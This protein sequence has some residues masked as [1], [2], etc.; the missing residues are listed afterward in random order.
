M[1]DGVASSEPSVASPSAVGVT[2]PEPRLATRKGRFWRS[3]GRNWAA[4]IGL[5]LLGVLIV[6]AIAA[7]IVAPYDPH[8]QNLAA[9]LRPLFWEPR[10]DLAH[11]L[12]TD[13]LGRDLLSRVIYGGRVSL[14]LG[15]LAVAISGM[16]GVTLGLLA[17]YYRGLIDR[18]VMRLADIQL[19][20]PFILLAVG[21][22]DVLGPGIGNLLLVL[23]IGGWV[24]YARL[25]RGETL[26]VREREYLEAARA[27]GQ[28]DL[29][30]ILR[31]VLPNVI[32][33]V[34][35]VATFA[36]AQNI[37]LESALSFL[38]MGAGPGTPSWGQMLS[39]SRPHLA[40]S[41][42]LAT[43]PGLAIMLTVLSIN[44]A[45]DW[46]QDYLDPRLSSE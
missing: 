17:G 29:W 8:E 3:L 24:V 31:H 34:I 10:G 33:P 20:M 12:G 13:Q 15:F 18:V 9:R 21:I 5:A 43:I 4:C 23:S 25:V 26:S 6:A 37:I 36:V 19:G 38:G 44:L 28:S 39:D 1:R 35:V 22:I 40:T 32:T 7:P 46:L 11:P 45:G 14:T 42:W 30:I 41:W 16:I 2:T 27:I